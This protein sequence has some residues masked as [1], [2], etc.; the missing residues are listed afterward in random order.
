MSS[1]SQNSYNLEPVDLTSNANTD[2]NK[3]F[4]NFFSPTFTVS[5][6]V[7]DAVISYFETVADNK[8]SA[9]ILASAVMYTARTRGVN[10]MSI[11]SEFTKLPKGEINSYL[12]MFLNLQRVGTSLLGLTTQPVTSKYVARAI[13][14]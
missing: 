5:P 8:E 4:N 6:N 9:K 12:A 14:P 1:T 2:A 3:Y 10:P 11:L 13:L 7:D